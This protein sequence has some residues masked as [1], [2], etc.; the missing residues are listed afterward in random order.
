[1]PDGPPD[2]WGPGG[3]ESWCSPGL[4]ASARERAIT[5]KIRSDLRPSCQKKPPKQQKLELGHKMYLQSHEC[6]FLL[7]YVPN[8]PLPGQ[9]LKSSLQ[10]QSSWSPHPCP[11]LH[12]RPGK[13]RSVGSL[14]QGKKHMYTGM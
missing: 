1:M 10:E 14:A 6:I 8:S 4:T 7:L 5:K 13:R 9:N 2:L 3:K 11:G 12:P